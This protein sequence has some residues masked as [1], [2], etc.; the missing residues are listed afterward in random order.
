MI[1]GLNLEIIFKLTI[2]LEC[3][4]IK[5][6]LFNWIRIDFNEYVERVGKALSKGPINSLRLEGF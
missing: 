4:L 2:H 5:L 6:K 1:V 3:G